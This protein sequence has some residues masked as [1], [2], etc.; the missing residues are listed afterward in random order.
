MTY[1]VAILVLLSGLLTS[2]AAQDQKPHDQKTM[3]DLRC[4]AAISDSA[5][6][7]EKASPG[8]T[9]IALMYYF[10]RL[11]GRDPGLDIE[12]ALVALSSTMTAKDVSEEDIRCGAEL[13]KR[14]KE[15]KDIGTHLMERMSKMP[16]P[17]APDHSL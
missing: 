5:E 9:V 12:N 1:G 2:A 4:I 13:S 11:D 6:I 17:A 7:V 14:G 15:M 10:G 16:P 8:S 3:E